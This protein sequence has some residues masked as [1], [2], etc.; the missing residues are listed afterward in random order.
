MFFRDCEHVEGMGGACG[1]GSTRR[2]WWCCPLSS[3]A[4]LRR[5]PAPTPSVPGLQEKVESMT[6][7]EYLEEFPE[8]AK[9]IDE[10]SMQNALMA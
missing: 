6:V 3:L 1:V 9:R 7:D 2:A 10:E 5:S 8:D 4:F